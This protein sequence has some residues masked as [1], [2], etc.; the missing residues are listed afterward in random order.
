VQR[1]PADLVRIEGA[2]V[3]PGRPGGWS[4]GTVSG[5]S[6]GRQRGPLSGAVGPALLS[7]RAG[8][9]EGHAELRRAA[10]GAGVGTGRMSYQRFRAPAPGWSTKS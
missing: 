7:P 3:T 8:P 1:R 4:L 9:A 5:H 10:P 6:S 2:G